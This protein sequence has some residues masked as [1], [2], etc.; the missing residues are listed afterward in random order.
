[1]SRYVP[2]LMPEIENR[3]SASVTIP[4][5]AASL[6]QDA[7]VALSSRGAG[8]RTTRAATAAPDPAAR[9]R[10]EMD[11]VPGCSTTSGSRRSRGGAC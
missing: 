6:R 1:M 10:P 7:A 2:G 11:A 3:P 5:F 4:D 8:T 9:T